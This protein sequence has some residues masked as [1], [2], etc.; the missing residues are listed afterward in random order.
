[1]KPNIEIYIDRIVLHDVDHMNKAE[2]NTA[3]QKHLTS[4]LAEKGITNGLMNQSYHRKLDG[5]KMYLPNHGKTTQVGSGIANGIIKSFNTGSNGVL[6]RS[7]F[8]P[9]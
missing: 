6:A 4:I 9:K 5:G 3:I 1:M 7:N 2:L 8:R